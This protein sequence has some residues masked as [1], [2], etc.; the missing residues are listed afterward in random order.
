VILST[1]GTTIKVAIVPA[2][3]GVMLLSQNFIGI[4]CGEQLNPAF[5]KA[6]LESPVGTFILT[7]K[8]SG[9]AIPTLRR[10]DIESIE[11]PD[12]TMIK[13]E[14][15]MS[16]FLQKEQLIEAEMKRLQQGLGDAKQTVLDEMGVSEVYEVQEE[17]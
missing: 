12:I 5:L 15:M 11:I 13:Q 4:R 3:N 16:G 6:Y 10:K 8:L 17:N 7:N 1:R 9:T 2:H 14:S